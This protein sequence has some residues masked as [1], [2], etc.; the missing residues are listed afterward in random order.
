M[1]RNQAVI[2]TGIASIDR[3]LKSLLPRLQKKVIRQGMRTGMKIIQQEAKARWPKVSGETR[4]G[5][6]VR[7]LKRSTKRI[8]VEV[9]IRTSST[10]KKITQAGKAVFYPAI[11][12]YKF[13]H[14]LKKAFQTK[15][16]AA[17]N[18]AMQAIHAGIDREASKG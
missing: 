15:G 17:R 4:R 8:A 18:A 13:K 7:A 12:E 14:I 2:V 9:R 11:V 10:L 5:I 3:R 1:A 6:K 16:K